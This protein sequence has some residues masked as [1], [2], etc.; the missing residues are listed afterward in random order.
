MYDDFR[1]LKICDTL[2]KGDNYKADIHQY[3]SGWLVRWC[4][5]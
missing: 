5:S 2:I 4:T 3:Y 1:L